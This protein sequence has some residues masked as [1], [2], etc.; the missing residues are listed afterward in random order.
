MQVRQAH[1]EVGVES[2]IDFE[3]NPSSEERIE[4]VSEGILK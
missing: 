1:E 3:M 2:S 4:N